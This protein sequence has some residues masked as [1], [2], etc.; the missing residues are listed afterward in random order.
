MA[1]ELGGGY[2]YLIEA[3]LKKEGKLSWWDE[4][5]GDLIKIDLLEKALPAGLAKLRKDFQ[6]QRDNLNSEERINPSDTGSS[7]SFWDGW[8]DEDLKDEINIIDRFLMYLNR[9]WPQES[10]RIA[11][12]SVNPDFERCDP[13][14]QESTED[15]WDPFAE[16][17]ALTPQDGEKT[18]GDISA[19]SPWEKSYFTPT[20][21]PEGIAETLTASF[22]NITPFGPPFSAMEQMYWAWK[23]GLFYGR[24]GGLPLTSPNTWP[25]TQ[26]KVPTAEQ[27]EVLV[28]FVSYKMYL[29]RAA[30]ATESGGS[31]ISAVVEQVTE[32]VNNTTRRN[33][34]EDLLEKE[35]AGEALT[36]EE[37]LRKKALL[38]ALE[39]GELGTKKI[40]VEDEDSL[41]ER[42]RH[43][44]QVMLMRNLKTFAQQYESL[45]KLR[46]RKYEKTYLMRGNPSEMINRLTLKP[47][48]SDF[49]NFR[50]DQISQL[51]P[52]FKIFQIVYDN[53]NEFKREVEF[54]FANRNNLPITGGDAPTGNILES[55]GR[56][57][58]GIKSFNWQ[59]IGTNP[60]TA[61]NDI[62]AELKLF[63]QSFDDLFEKRTAIDDE[64]E[65]FSYRYVDLILRNPE[66]DGE[67]VISKENESL[68]DPSEQHPDKF[69]T[70]IIV[71]WNFRGTELEEKVK[72][73]NKNISDLSYFNEVLF[74]TLIDHQ[75]DIEEDGT[76]GLTVTYRA[77][78]DAMM[79]DNK[80]DVLS[81]PEIFNNK[82]RI[83]KEIQKL[84][85]K[86]NSSDEVKE[87]LKAL[88]EE[89]EK[90][91]MKWRQTNYQSLL[92]E[93]LG[94]KPNF[95]NESRIYLI[96]I[97]MAK[98]IKG[99][100]DLSNL[101]EMLIGPDNSAAISPE[102]V[103]ESMSSKVSKSSPKKIGTSE[104][105]KNAADASA[106]VVRNASRTAGTDDPNPKSTIETGAAGAVALLAAASPG[107]G[108][109]A[110]SSLINDYQ[111]NSI[112]NTFQKTGEL[113]EED[114]NKFLMTSVPDSKPGE[115]NIH[116]FFFGDLIEMI[117]SRALTAFKIE[118]ETPENRQYSQSKLDKIKVLLGTMEWQTLASG[119]TEK[120]RCNLGALP[121]SL[122][123]YKNFMLRRVVAKK[124][125]TYTLLDFIRDFLRYLLDDVLMGNSE[126]SDEDLKLDIDVKSNVITMPG[127]NQNIDPIKDKINETR[128]NLIS[129]AA[130]SPSQSP[131]EDNWP[132]PTLDLDTITEQNTIVPYGDPESN[133]S[134]EAYHY[135]AI[136]VDNKKPT[137][138][139][140]D[141]EKDKAAGIY[142]FH[143]GESSGIFKRATFNRTDAKY[144]REARF[145]QKHY[146]PLRT[147]SSVYDIDVE[148]FGNSIFYPGQYLFVNPFGLGK[149]LGFP[150]QENS[151][152]NIMGLGG[153]HMITGVE[154]TMDEDGFTTSVTARYEA[155]GDGKKYA[156]KTD[157]TVQPDCEAPEATEIK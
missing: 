24:N 17:P 45:L 128:K 53:N 15:C 154:S 78:L 112:I 138:L 4:E 21:W 52:K 16:L 148:M 1:G 91:K 63:F 54:K 74:M 96:S 123:N 62:K 48:M 70:K 2:W 144:L 135:L 143:I 141:E 50:T 86:C 23:V 7:S 124:R 27:A 43:T 147:L 83:E 99:G 65:V 59:Y 10:A 87:E 125:D 55:R 149:S 3:A 92:N 20:E 64:G 103:K 19:A 136:Y 114:I 67:A 134:R 35:A 25:I 13:A 98:F 113:S 140:G 38:E 72:R 100:E 9:G 117:A 118:G 80:S 146:D 94:V 151:L 101:E 152:S 81:T 121:V 49:L 137:H 142:H 127:K 85:K 66:V 73:D 122:Q 153:Y 34:L 37:E 77:R 41:A 109:A 79:Q 61:R 95:P 120:F 76:L 97:D 84:K 150:N 106:D 22:E 39:D 88:K 115:Y 29:T 139:R 44:E 71:G 40:E 116:Y 145:T 8:T 126:D 57:A 108:A 18:G 129:R 104:S 31:T 90:R 155:S 111:T 75:F 131:G 5:K 36:V 82:M 26:F 6:S 30:K 28:R 60:V 132:G 69:E 133:S 68:H 14:N 157:E 51:A 93:M 33:T 105:I 47:H 11:L 110:V 119:K 130:S 46:K 56:E 32:V 58:V 102:A 156:S 12:N 89:Y 107:T 42:I